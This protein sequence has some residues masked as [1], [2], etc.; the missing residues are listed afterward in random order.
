MEFGTTGRLAQA[1]A[2]AVR[3]GVDKEDAVAKIGKLKER[4]DALE[5]AGGVH[6]RSRPGSML[7]IAPQQQAQ[8]CNHSVQGAQ[9]PQFAS[10]LQAMLKERELFSK[11]VPRKVPVTWVGSA[12]EVRNVSTSCRRPQ[13]P[14]SLKPAA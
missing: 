2:A 4:L 8:L 14:L 7:C 1:A 9:K 6:M 10:G 11:R 13:K 3:F 12:N 5:K